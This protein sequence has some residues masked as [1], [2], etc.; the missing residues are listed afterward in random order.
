MKR[1]LF[2]VSLTILLL[3]PCA[4]AGDEEPLRLT[5]GYIYKLRCEGRLLISAIG[6]DA[7]LRLE[8]LPKESGC[9]AV[10]KPL[11]PTGT[12]NLLL[13][14]STGSVSRWVEVSKA[15]SLRSEVSPF[16]FFLRPTAEALPRGKFK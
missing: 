2:A 1:F 3:C 10:L 15:P 4:R 12:T 14:T 11:G 5:S 13:E 6:N 16:E 8:P 7:L 9:G